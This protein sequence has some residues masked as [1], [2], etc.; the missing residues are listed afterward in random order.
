[1]IAQAP[2]LVVRPPGCSAPGEKRSEETRAGSDM[3]EG[4]LTGGVGDTSADS[5]RC[6]PS[7]PS[8]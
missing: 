8:R 6:E 4:L 3:R 5:S 7:Q 1:M 2:A